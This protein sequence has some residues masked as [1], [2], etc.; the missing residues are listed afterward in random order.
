M[1]IVEACRERRIG[2]HLFPSPR[3]R[4]G[5]SDVALSKTLD[6][7]GEAGRIHGFR[8]SFR[9]WVQDTGAAGYDIAETALGHVVGG[10]VE[11]A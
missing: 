7:L 1:R 3:L 9:T 10:K 5:I 4:K 2:A 8:T 6:R 11:R